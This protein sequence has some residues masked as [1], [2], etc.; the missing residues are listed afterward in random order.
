MKCKG[1]FR[2]GIAKGWKLIE[3]SDIIEIKNCEWC[4]KEADE[5]MNVHCWKCGKKLNKKNMRVTR[6]IIVCRECD[7]K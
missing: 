4:K 1:H 7:E 3:P 5:K 6:D 2:T